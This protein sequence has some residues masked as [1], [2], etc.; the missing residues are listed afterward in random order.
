MSCVT[1]GFCLVTWRTSYYL[2][3]ELNG[4]PR[5][6][7]LFDDLSSS[8]NAPIRMRKPITSFP[9]I[10]RVAFGDN[11]CVFLSSVL[12]FELFSC[13][14]IF[15][16]LLGDHLH[17]LFPSVSQSKH[18]TI[19]AGILTLPSALLRTPKLLS[20]LSAVGTFAT[21]AVV[22]A[23]V[24]SAL[25]MFFT[26]G[27]NYAGNEREYQ[28]YSSDGL[29]LALGFVAYCFSGHAIVPTIDIFVSE[30]IYLFSIGLLTNA[31]CHNSCVHTVYEH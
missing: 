2:G 17:V 29:P 14:S 7:H 15:F 18:M 12:Y 31:S 10:A 24:L 16:V 25:V 22:S 11:G 28:L 4:D 13:L 21:V 26:V 30:C 19:V 20:Y 8:E 5:P 3:R 23:V 1:I 6:V 9:A 27:D